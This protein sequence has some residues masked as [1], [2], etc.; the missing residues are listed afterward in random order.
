MA[1][2]K[3]SFNKMTLQFMM[4]Y[5]EENYPKDKPWF[6]SV[7]YDDVVP[8]MRVPKTVNGQP[9]MKFSKRQNKL[10]VAYKMVPIEGAPAVPHFNLLKAKRAFCERYM[11]ELLPKS[12]GKHKKPP[13]SESLRDW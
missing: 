6:K 8:T 7:A 11:P 2:E 4:D 13:V 3:I 5:I 10:V 12:Q 1:K 9:I